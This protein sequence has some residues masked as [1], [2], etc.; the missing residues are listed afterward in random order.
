MNEKL[1]SFCTEDVNAAASGLAG[2]SN[3]AL[4]MGR[5][6]TVTMAVRW[7]PVINKLQYQG[8]DIFTTDRECA[9]ALDQMRTLL[10]DTSEPF[11]AVG[12]LA[13]EVG[14]TTQRECC[15]LQ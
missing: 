1:T 11:L 12:T 5:N 15:V 8:E 13:Q 7:T 2:T 9:T 6:V 10:G 4:G 14:S 3:M